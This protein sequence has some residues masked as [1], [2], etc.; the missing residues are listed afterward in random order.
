[1]PDERGK[2]LAQWVFPEYDKPHRGRL[3]YII[4]IGLV[5]LLLVIAIRD[6]NFLFAL[7]ILLFTL[8]IFTHHRTEPVDLAF[9]IYETGIQIGD[10]FYFF[11]EINSFAVIYEPPAVK[12]LYINPRGNVIR[13]QISIPL[14]SQNPVKLRSILLDYIEEDLDHDEESPNDMATRLFKL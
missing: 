14:F 1:M 7:I 6:A 13:N 2:I 9:T 10:R 12:R 11:R 3:W 4:S 8:I 5:L